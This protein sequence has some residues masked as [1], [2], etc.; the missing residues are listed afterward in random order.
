M[1]IY[2]RGIMIGLVMV[3]TTIMATLVQPPTLV[4]AT[5]YEGT[6]TLNCEGWVANDGSVFLTRDNTGRT[7]RFGGPLE[8][9]QIVGY[10]GAGTQ[11][12]FQEAEAELGEKVNGIGN[13]T[14]WMV[15]PEYNP[16]TFQF[17]SLAGNGL[18]EV[19][20]F[21][22]TGVCPG[23]PD[24]EAPA[25][26]RGCDVQMPITK[27]AVVGRFIVDTP[28]YWFPGKMI[29]PELVIKGGNTAWVLGVDETGQYRKIIWVCDLLWVPA[30]AM[31]P[32]DDAI[33]RG[34]PLPTEIVD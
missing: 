34:A 3:L 29:S 22:A 15:P 17:I 11:I 9:F 2:R 19:L 24:F 14:P 31:G 8:R 10:D 1:R 32:N 33:W 23:L 16:L 30:G 27:T 18:P 5:S 7:G 21:E 26:P 12:Y 25:A 4:S 6:A 20:V 28:T 13:F